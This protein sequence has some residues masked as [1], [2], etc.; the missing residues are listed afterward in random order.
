MQRASSSRKIPQSNVIIERIH[1]VMLNMLRTLELSN[2]VWN[3]E[4]RIWDL[5]L[6][7][8]S[9]AIRSAFNT[10]SKF[11]PRQLAF[12]YNMISQTQYS[13]NQELIKT[14]KYI[15]QL[16][17]IILKKTIIELLGITK[18]ETK[19]SLTTNIG[20][21]TNHTLDLLTSLI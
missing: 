6:S 19:F 21:L 5:Y 16:L 9:W 10:T 2:V 3:N 4:D 13:V 18:L 17:M 8:I 14:N 12:N 11:L 20:N 1:L 15:I 7:K